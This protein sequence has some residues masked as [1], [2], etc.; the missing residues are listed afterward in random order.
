LPRA[1]PSWEWSLQ[2][3]A[4]SELTRWTNPPVVSASA[5][6]FLTLLVE[7]HG[8]VVP[9]MIDHLG[10]ANETS[11]IPLL[12]KVAA[13]ECLGLR[14]IYFRIKAVEALGKM[15]VIE[16]APLLL[17]IVRERN[18]L[19]RSEPAA[20]RVAAEEA[21][22]LLEDRTSS[23]RPRAREKTPAK[24]AMEHGRPRRYV[25]AQLSSPLPATIVGTHAGALRVQILSLGGA[26]LESDR[27]LAVGESLR[28][29]MR[30]GLRRIQFTAVVRN[31]TPSG[32]GVEFVHMKPD[33][34]ERL[35]RLV[36]QALQ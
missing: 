22:G 21:L 2:D 3:L 19:A 25:R 34:R 20:L 15:R 35:R 1:L 32:A 8:M 26:F 28:V 23:A 24:S 10:S 16:A 33:D 7:A 9:G 11:A 27:R 6:A 18:G 31:V 14:D 36:A 17:R 12:L 4:V 13:G 29:E 5:K 30:A